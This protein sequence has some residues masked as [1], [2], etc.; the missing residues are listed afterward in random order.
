MIQEAIPGKSITTLLCE[1]YFHNLETVI[2]VIK[3]ILIALSFCHQQ[4]YAHKAINP[5]HVMVVKLN[6]GSSLLIKLVGFG[7]A[8]KIGAP[9]ISNTVG[10]TS[11]FNA[12]EAYN[13]HKADKQ[14]I[15]SCG[16][17]LL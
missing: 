12:P 15:W 9:I 11:I 5:E 17:I 1:D 8:H 7:S 14:D 10:H 16:I 3:Q 6:R 2:E 13:D 4:G